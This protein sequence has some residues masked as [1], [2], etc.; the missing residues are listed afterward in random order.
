M[1][2]ESK[3]VTSAFSEGVLKSAPSKRKPFTQLEYAMKFL[4]MASDLLT[5]GQCVEDQ[6]RPWMPIRDV[7]IFSLFYSS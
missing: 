2:S 5:A 6:I 1:H 3:W 4:S 7:L